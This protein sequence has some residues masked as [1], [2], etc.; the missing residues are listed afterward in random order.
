[1]EFNIELLILTAL[2]FWLIYF[3]LAFLFPTKK[4]SFF[5]IIALC[6]Q[7]VWVVFRAYSSGH[8]PFSG[9]YETIIFFSLLYSIKIIF[10]TGFEGRIRLLLLVPVPVLI[11]TAI[12]LPINLKTSGMV[13]PA[14]KSAWIFIH[15]PLIFIGYVSLTVGFIQSWI[16]FFTGNNID[17]ADNEIKLALF[18]IV[19]GIITGGFWAEAAWG[20][21]WTWDPKETWAL[22]AWLFLVLVI[23]FRNMRNALVIRL[24]IITLA[25]LSMLFTYFGVTFLLPGLHSYL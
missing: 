18:F 22:I 10:L 24:I 13:M 1:M 16:L 4:Y 14:L 2:I 11:I 8:A 15:V 25:F 9:I 3:V 12:L 6:F 5:P 23:H 7:L 17:R 19:A 20:S 21:F